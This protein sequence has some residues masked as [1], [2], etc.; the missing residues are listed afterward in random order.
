[1]PEPERGREFTGQEVRDR[2][3]DCDSTAL[4]RFGAKLLKPAATASVRLGAAPVPA[5]SKYRSNDVP[6][7]P[8]MVAS[9][10]PAAIWVNWLPPP[11]EMS[12]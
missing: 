10:E 6:T 2:P 7:L 9:A 11:M 3:A 8:K 5:V 1:M 4:P 12:F